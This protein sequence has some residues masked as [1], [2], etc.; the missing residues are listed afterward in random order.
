[1]APTRIVRLP[2]RRS[3]PARSWPD[4]AALAAL[5][6]CWRGAGLDL[7]RQLTELRDQAAVA[8]YEAC[9]CLIATRLMQAE[10][11]PPSAACMFKA[12]FDCVVMKDEFLQDPRCI[13]DLAQK[14]APTLQ[15]KQ[16]LLD[17][18]KGKLLKDC[19]CVLLRGPEE[20]TVE[21]L[22]EFYATLALCAAFERK[23]ALCGPQVV[24]TAAK[25]APATTTTAGQGVDD[26][27]SAAAKLRPPRKK[28]KRRSAAPP[29]PPPGAALAAARAT[30]AR[31]WNRLEA[32]WVVQHT[33]LSFPRWALVLA[34]AEAEAG[35]GGVPE[36]AERPQPR[37]C[38]SC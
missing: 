9:R 24:V 33:F 21:G 8:V 2:R 23:A 6:A 34:E 10:R 20:T 13:E 17:G 15:R 36:A 30:L 5:A 32:E 11:P 26:G 37:R 29:P 19:G 14:A 1:M 3:P 16:K 31:P 38:Q 18:I 35:A 25:A 22:L 27:G 28:A 4:R 12:S 7:R